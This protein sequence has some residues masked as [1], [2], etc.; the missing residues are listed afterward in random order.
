MAKEKEAPLKEA[1][2]KKGG[3]TLS[4]LAQYDDLATDVLVDKVYFWAIIRKNRT[5][6]APV[7]NIHEED[8]ARILRDSVVINKDPVRAQEQLL[9]LPG[10]KR[11]LAKLATK[12]E[13]EHFKRHFRKYVNL[14]MPDC[15]WEVSTTNRYTITQ[16]EAAVTARRDIRKNEAIKYLC[17]IQ[18]AMTKEEEETLDL[19]KRD[20]SIVMSS[21][22]KAPSLFLG[23]ARFANHDCDPNARLTTNGPNGMAIVSKKD[24]E[25][26]EEITVSYGE[27]YFGDDNCECL[28]ATCEKLARNGWGPP[29][30]ETDGDAD[31]SENQVLPQEG[32]YSFRKKRRYATDSATASRDTTTEPLA[33][34]DGKKK[35]DTPQ[36]SHPSSPRGKKRKA[37]EVEEQTRPLS[38][39]SESQ[40]RHKTIDGMHI[41]MERTESQQSQDTPQSSEEEPGPMTTAMARLRSIRSHQRDRLLAT[42]LAESESASA[43]SPGSFSDASQHSSQSTAATSVDEDLP[44]S[45]P[46]DGTDAQIKTEIEVEQIPAIEIKV[47]SSEVQTVKPTNTSNPAN[48]PLEESEL[49]ELS[50]SVAFDDDNQQL[51]R[52]KR[53]NTPPRTRSQNGPTSSSAPIPTIENPSNPGDEPLD[54]DRRYPGDY[55]LTSLLLCAKYSRWVSCRTCEA[56]FVQ[57]DAYLTRAACPRCER[58]SKLYGYAWPKTDKEGKHDKEERVKDHREINRFVSPSEEREIRKGK[59]QLQ[60]VIARRASELSERLGSESVGADGEGTPSSLRRGMRKRSSRLSMV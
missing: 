22:K 4:Q 1:L 40:K 34:E 50:D 5:R 43:S 9:E 44:A 30:K 16:H 31:D 3:L 53:L 18:V 10:L 20:F 36:T 45:L 6:Y 2:S 41:K 59:K 52:Q 17:G 55:T 58:H 32:P 38:S 29:K 39:G 26:G 25:A 54:P 60:M 49:S 42:T 14:Y 47:D 19:N 8:I 35:V 28:C 12:D 15:P 56:D 27:D 37:D 21:R 23:P 7:R 13:K 48:E 33:R 24:I 51:I 11:Y 46:S 57:E